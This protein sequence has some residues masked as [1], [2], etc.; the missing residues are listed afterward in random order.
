MFHH[1][2]KSPVRIVEQI[3]ERGY[4]KWLVAIVG[5][6]VIRVVSFQIQLLRIGMIA[7]AKLG[8]I[9]TC[10]PLHSL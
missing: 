1:C 5:N 4:E 6:G 3:I 10:S 8:E 9:M 2:A 7:T